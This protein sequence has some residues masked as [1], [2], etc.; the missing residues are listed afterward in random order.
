M[1]QS[2]HTQTDATDGRSLI[3]RVLGVGTRQQTYLNVV[4]LLARFPLGMVYFTIF[5]TGLALGVSLVPVV[6][7]LPIL[8]GVIGLAGYVGVIETKL[9]N[10]LYGRDMS[11]TIADPQAL[12]ITEYLKAIVTAPCNYLLIL[13][14]FGSFVIGLQM[15]VA[16]IVVFTL[17]LTLAVAPL[18]YWIPGIEYEL[19]QASGTV[20][21]GSVAI[22]L[23]SMTG[24]SINTLPEALVVSALGIICCFVGLH[25]I[26]LIAWAFRTLT[27]RLLK[28]GTTPE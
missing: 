5:V 22:D 19:T 1:A 20:D 3:S 7:G 23:G 14:A 8:A 2:Q 12:S 16:I 27:L 6:V 15:F 11:H 18:V 26:N 24:A 4:Y 10:K 25:V 9:L 21:V 28:F 17:A 13:F